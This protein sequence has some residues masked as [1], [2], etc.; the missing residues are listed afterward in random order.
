MLKP[1]EIR[2]DKRSFYDGAEPTFTES[3]VAEIQTYV[4]PATDTFMEFA[5]FGASENDNSFDFATA[6]Q[7][8]PELEPFFAAVLKET[9]LVEK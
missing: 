7:Q 8:A 4:A 1:V 9:N 3:Y 6:M 2:Y 5:M